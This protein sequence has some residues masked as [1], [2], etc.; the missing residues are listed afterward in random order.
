[1]I[2]FSYQSVA[3]KGAPS[4]SILILTVSFLVIMVVAYRFYG[5]WVAR[6]FVIDD[7]RVTPAHTAKD[8]I[9][10]IPTRPF[11]LFAQHFSAIA[12]AGPDRR[13]DPCLSDLRLAAVP[14]VDRAWSRADR[15]GA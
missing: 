9:D 5:G 1:M 8:G 7:K 2:P 3:G 6:Q 11:Y 13:A 14:A 4:V 10:Y 12:A 15:G